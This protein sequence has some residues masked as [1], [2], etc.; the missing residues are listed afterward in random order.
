M[1]VS[2]IT[3]AYNSVNTIRDTFESIKSQNYND[4]EYIVVDG[5]STDGT[6]DIIEEYSD[7]ITKSISESDK[8]IYDAMNKG[9]KMATGEIVGIL[10]S[11]DFYFDCNVI[12]NIVKV[13][14]SNNVDSVYSDIIY[15][16]PNNTSKVDRYWKSCKYDRKKFLYGWMPAHPSFFV[17][18]DVYKNFGVFNEVLKS[19]ADYEFMLRVLYKNKISS[20]YLSKITVIMRSGG[21]SNRSLKSRINGNKEDRKAWNINNI[22]PYFFTLF[23]KPL[24]KLSQFFYKPMQTI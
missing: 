22:E 16:D 21:N 20:K 17:K 2:I 4:I 7:V 11:D 8:G 9:V 13:F 18:K 1:K 3:V 24:R 23:L 15:V 5:F 12:S 19:A 6:L 14:K 10:N